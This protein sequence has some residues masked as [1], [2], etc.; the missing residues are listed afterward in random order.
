MGFLE[1]VVQLLLPATCPGC[2]EPA[3]ALCPSCEAGLRPAPAAA[4]PTGL[5]WW[6]SAY[7]YE[8][9]LRELVARAKYRQARTGLGWLAASVVAG[10]ETGLTQ[11]HGPLDVVTWPPTTP[12]RRRQRGF[13]AAEL[14]ARAVA[15]RLRLPVRRLLVRTAGGAQTGRRRAARRHGPEFAA[16]AAVA[17]GRILLVDDVTTTGATLSAAAAALRAAGAKGVLGATA[18]RTP[19]QVGRM[20]RA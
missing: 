15:P 9:A 7:S 10:I 18:G 19:L 11:G 6:V 2:G 3:V 20:H 8:G 16:C 13:D 12:G 1:A 14:L 5:D 17:G 4:P